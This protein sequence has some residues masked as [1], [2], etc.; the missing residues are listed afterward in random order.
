[1]GQAPHPPVTVHDAIS[2]L[3]GFEYVNPCVVYPQDNPRTLSLPQLE[4]PKT[5]HCGTEVQEYAY[6]PSSTF[7]LNRRR[8]SPFAA[9][10]VTRCFNPLTVERI[11][12]V[13]MKPGQD[14]SSK[15]FD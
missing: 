14:H 7:Q 15:V 1:M 11:C 5:G 10:H 6:P 2:D 3:P 9:N 13:G 12:R 8:N 4:M